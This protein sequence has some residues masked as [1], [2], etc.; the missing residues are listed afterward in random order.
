MNFVFTDEHKKRRLDVVDLS[1]HER[2]ELEA[3]YQNG[4]KTKTEVLDYF[5]Q[6]WSHKDE[7]AIVEFVEKV[8]A[9]STELPILLS[10]NSYC[11]TEAHKDEM[12]NYYNQA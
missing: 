3:Y 11:F 12:I 10:N 9:T 6:K 2:A 8:T 7:Q 4:E 5:K 1:E